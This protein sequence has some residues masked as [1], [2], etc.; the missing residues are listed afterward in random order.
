[1]NL[2]NTASEGYP[3]I[4]VAKIVGISVIFESWSFLE[5]DA[6]FLSS[7]FTCFLVIMI[8]MALLLIVHILVW[9]YYEEF[10]LFYG[11]FF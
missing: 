5:V 2:K 8:F 9:Q 11:F 6:S 7:T 10:T 4:F 1:M 3:W